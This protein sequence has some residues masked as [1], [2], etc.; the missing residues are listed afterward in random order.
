ML[1]RALS[2]QIHIDNLFVCQWKV[3]PF[4]HKYSTLFFYPYIIILGTRGSQLFS[5][6]SSFSLLEFSGPLGSCQIHWNFWFDSPTRVGRSFF[7]AASWHGHL[8]DVRPRLSG[9]LQ[10]GSCG[11]TVNEGRRA[12]PSLVTKNRN[13]W[14][15]KLSHKSSCINASKLF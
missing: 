12:R 5:A 7:I 14:S 4:P 2:I 3:V 10:S 15:H 11:N 6:L 1:L 9:F 13:W 8:V